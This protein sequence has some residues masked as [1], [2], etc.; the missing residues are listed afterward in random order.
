MPSISI[1]GTVTDHG[2]RP[3]M[4]VPLTVTLTMSRDDTH[5]NSTTSLDVIAHTDGSFTADFPISSDVEDGFTVSGAPGSG[6]GTAGGRVA[7]QVDTR[8]PGLGHT[9]FSSP[10]VALFGRGQTFESVANSLFDDLHLDTDLTGLGYYHF[11]AV[12]SEDDKATLSALKNVD[13]MTCEILH[14]D[15]R[16]PSML[17]RSAPGKDGAPSDPDV[18]AAVQAFDDAILKGPG[19][20]QSAA[21][22]EQEL[23]GLRNDIEVAADPSIAL[24][25]GEFSVFASGR[26]QWNE[27]GSFYAAAFLLRKDQI[28]DPDFFVRFRS[29]GPDLTDDVILR[30]IPLTLPWTS[31]GLV[32]R[33]VQASGVGTISSSLD[34]RLYSAPF[35]VVNPDLDL[36]DGKIR[37]RGRVGVGTGPNMMIAEIASIDVTLSLAIHDYR[38]VPFS[39]DEFD[40][41]FDVGVTKTVVDILPGTDLDELPAW[42]YAAISVLGFPIGLAGVGET[43]AVIAAIEFALRPVVSSMVKSQAVA[44][45]AKQLHQ[46]VNKE[47]DD[48]IAGSLANSAIPISAEEQAALPATAWFSPESLTIDD[49]DVTVTGFAGLWNNIVEGINIDLSKRRGAPRTRAQIGR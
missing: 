48:Q 8:P 15:G 42:V 26:A 22:W 14:Q 23:D 32:S 10:V 12:V 38:D 18:D 16:Q 45:I 4:P 13:T 31:Y 47:V 27:D 43:E 3:A 28:D 44:S 5:F 29:A 11:T 7:V 24:P 34:D 46:R 35:V 20:G 49:D 25:S 30:S 33:I 40:G 39:M 19:K 6:S 21:S 2:K 41:L 36:V 9:D 37:V 1:R 17:V